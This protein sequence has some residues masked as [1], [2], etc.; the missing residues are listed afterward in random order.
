MSLYPTVN[1]YSAYVLGL[2]PQKQKKNERLDHMPAV[3]MMS[4]ACL[5]TETDRLIS[6]VNCSL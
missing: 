1:V 2:F 3:S 5:S 4:I 6:L